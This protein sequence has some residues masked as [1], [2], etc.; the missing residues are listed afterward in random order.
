MPMRLRF[1]R[2]YDHD[3]GDKGGTITYAGGQLYDVPDD[4]AAAVTAGDDPIAVDPDAKDPEAPDPDAPKP[5]EPAFE[6]D[7]NPEPAEPAELEE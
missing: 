1:K 2:P 7:A 6:L 4:V 5:E 3:R